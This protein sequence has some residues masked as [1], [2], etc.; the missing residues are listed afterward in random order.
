MKIPGLRS[1][2]ET[3]G[4]IVFFGG[5][6]D[7]IR[8][9]AQGKLPADYQNNLGIGSDGRTVRFLRVEYTKLVERVRQGGADEEILQWCFAHGRT[10]S[11]EEILIWN[12]FMTKRGWRDETAPDLERMKQERGFSDRDDIQTFFDFH[13]G[14]E[15]DSSPPTGAIT[16][17]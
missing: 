17:K 15:D 1:S 9:H 10:P 7:K 14:D 2:Y 5:M 3:V 8:L 11:E 13:R 16:S 12:A 6:L 4:G